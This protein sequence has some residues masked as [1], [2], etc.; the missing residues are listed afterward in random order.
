MKS[1]ECFNSTHFVC[2]LYN[3]IIYK[4][5]ITDTELATCKRYSRISEK[6]GVKK[7]EGNI[8]A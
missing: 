1:V 5:K 3:L 6:N 2:K 8:C 4:P 7:L